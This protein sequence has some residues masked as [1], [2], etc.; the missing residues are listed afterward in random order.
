LCFC[1]RRNYWFI[2]SVHN[3]KWPDGCSGKSPLEYK[4]LKGV[5]SVGIEQMELPGLTDSYILV[6]NNVGVVSKFS[7]LSLL[8][9]TAMKIKHW[10]F[11]FL[12]C[13]SGLMYWTSRSAT[14]Y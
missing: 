8:H 4:L 1:C 10:W 11:H 9:G 14:E 12:H 5:F 2:K 13:C 7:P 3:G 6:H